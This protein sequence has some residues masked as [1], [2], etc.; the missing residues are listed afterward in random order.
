MTEQ[1]EETQEKM[2]RELRSALE[3]MQIAQEHAKACESERVEMKRRLHA[4]EEG[5]KRDTELFRTEAMKR[6]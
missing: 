1:Y 4:M 5:Y 3:E 6:D 2:T